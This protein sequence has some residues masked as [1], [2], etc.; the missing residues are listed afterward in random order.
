MFLLFQDLK[1]VAQIL[2]FCSSFLQTGLVYT[3]SR[4]VV[5][6]SQ[7]YL[8]LYLTE[9]LKFEKVSIKLVINRGGL[10]GLLQVFSYDSGR[11]K[12]RESRLEPNLFFS[13]PLT[14]RFGL[15][16]ELL[17]QD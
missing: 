13:A 5:N 15:L 11:A 14:A 8:P 2:I 12:T 7:S 3:C 17:E 6:V 4:L 1:R 10:N 16:T 9:T